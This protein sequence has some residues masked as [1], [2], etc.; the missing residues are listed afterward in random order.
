M[1]IAFLSTNLPFLLAAIFGAMFPILSYVV[2]GLIGLM[3][4]LYI[5]SIFS[6]KKPTVNGSGKNVKVLKKGFDIPV[7]GAPQGEVLA[8]KTTRFALQPKNFPYIF[9]IPKVPVKVGDH[10]HA[11]DVLFYDRDRPKVKFASPVSG[12]VIEIQRGAKRSIAEIVVE[13]D[14][15]QSYRE[16]KSINLET[17][18]REDLVDFLAENGVWPMINQRPYDVIPA[19]DAVPRDIFVTTFDTAPLAPDASKII[20]GKEVAFQGG[21]DI[22]RKLTSGKV[23]LGLDGRVAKVST[24]FSEAHGVEKHWF[25]G[26]HP[27]GNVGVQI[28]H[29]A[30][31]KNG[32]DIV[33]TLGVQE[34]ASIGALVTGQKYDASRVVAVGGNQVEK[35]KYVQTYMGAMMGDLLEGDGQDGR[36]ISGDMLTGE[37]K[38]RE[39]FLN[40]FDN[41]VTVIGEGDYFEMFGWAMPTK[42]TP[43]VSKTYWRGLFPSGKPLDIDAN[44]HGEKRAFV[45]T[46]EYE[47]MLPMDIYPQHLMKAIITADYEKMEGLGIHELS[48]EDIALCE[49]A[50]TSKQPLQEILRQ[51]LSELYAE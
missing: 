27:T 51:G 39:E 24:A 9:P 7:K 11:G 17:I 37:K 10:V 45:M 49:F 22:L 20:A 33:W 47:R 1:S 8:A 44:L 31:I 35:P 28:H 48:E 43:T 25:A 19:L 5:G 26:F 3:A 36:I 13:A 32:E 34:V 23:H 15:Q 38:Q 6:Q 21:L 46:G 2:Y 16:V 18:S 50:C 29:I 40:Y 14:G 41:Q 12:K 30:P 4:L 42:K